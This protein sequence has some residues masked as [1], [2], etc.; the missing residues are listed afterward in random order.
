MK[1]FKN[2]RMMQVRV[3]RIVFREGTDV[4]GKAY[5]MMQVYFNSANE[6]VGGFDNRDLNISF[7]SSSD[8]YEM[9]NRLPKKDD[10]AADGTA[11]KVITAE[12]LMKATLPT[13]VVNSKKVPLNPDDDS[14]DPDDATTYELVQTKETIPAV[15]DPI[16]LNWKT[17]LPRPK[18]DK[19]AQRD[20]IDEHPNEVPM[21]IAVATMQLSNDEATKWRLVN[22][23][24][25]PIT[26]RIHGVEMPIEDTETTVC[27]QC[28]YGETIDEETGRGTGEFDFN[29]DADPDIV[30]EDIRRN[31]YEPVK[32]RTTGATPAPAEA[33][34]DDLLA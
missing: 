33:A 21:R 19:Y 10:E 26:R 11:V 29:W 24:G 2:L 12:M 30:L 9:F 7:N 18:G 6:G 23:E 25:Q 8:I 5:K 20:F 32:S 34:A 27:W 15:L 17:I 3:T 4:K 31:R 22:K 13:E 1:K 28:T 16:W 14:F